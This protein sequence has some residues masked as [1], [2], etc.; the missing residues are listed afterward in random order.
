VTGTTG[1]G[2]SR[3]F[4]RVVPDILVVIS[5]TVKLIVPVR[6]NTIAFEN[7]FDP[8]SI[9]VN[10]IGAPHPGIVAA[11]LVRLVNTTDPVYQIIVLLELSLACIVILSG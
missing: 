9:G 5:R 7:V 10:T 3:I 11:V 8:A 1:G 2:V 6:V 4:I